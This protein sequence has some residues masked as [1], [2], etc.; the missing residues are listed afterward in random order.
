MRNDLP[1]Q[2]W[3]RWALPLLMLA[4]SAPL[5]LHWREP[6]LF[7]AINQACLLLPAPV[8]TGLSLLGNTWGVL[9]ATS[10][11]LVLAPR[12]LWAW[13]CAVPFGVLF[14]RLGKGFL[15]SP[16]P[17]AV[18]DNSLFRLVGEKLEVASMPSGHTLTA[19]A[20]ASSLYFALDARGR[21]RFAWLWLLA[22]AV[23]L[24]RIA[25]GAHWP[26]DVAVGAG[27]GVLAGLLGN[28]LW[29]RLGAVYA[30]PQG[31][32]LRA[33]AV[34]LAATVYVLL[35]EPLDFVQNTLLQQVLAVV[36]TGV[37]AVFA[38]RQRGGSSAKAG[39]L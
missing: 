6:A 34:L 13:L 32:R 30:Q 36:V 29:R 28:L 39:G 16:R 22:G 9:A 25:V 17:A 24:S 18:V 1:P 23:G 2:T 5:W 35:D 20:V 37:L 19:F 15:D 21:A 11:L 26:G 27:L 10:P 31:W 38:W 3:R 8:W 14:A 12:L 4:L 33:V 7:V